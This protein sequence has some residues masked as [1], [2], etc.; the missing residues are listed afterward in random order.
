[1]SN[2][3]SVS[4]AGTSLRPAPYVSTTYEYN[5][6][7]QYVI[8]GFLVVTL[9]GTVVDKDII[10]AIKSLSALQ[11]NSDCVSLTIGCSGGTDFI[12]GSGR[13]RS[14]TINPSDQP[15][16]VSYSV[17]I[18]LETIDNNPA[19]EADDEFVNSNCLTA[20]VS[21]LQSYS[22]TL[23]VS[24]DANTI[25]SVDKA[26]DVSKSYI[27]ASGKIV[28]VSYMRN[29][30]GFPNYNGLDNSI[31]ILEDRAKSLMNMNV[32]SI[33]NDNPLSQ[34]SGWNKWLD[35]KSLTIDSNGVVTWSFDMY[36][37][38]GGATPFA[39][40]DIDTEDSQDQQRKSVNL[41]RR[42]SGSIKG[43]SSANISD[44]LANRVD[45][46]ERLSNAKSAFS[47][48]SGIITN[49][50]WPEDS[51]V[52]T[53]ELNCTPPPPSSC[54]PQEEELCLQ[55]ISST[56]KESPISGEITFNAEFAPISACQPR[57][58]GKVDL[59]VEENLP[60]ERHVEYII[61]GNIDSVVVSLNAKTPHRVNISVRGSL[62]GC[63]KTKMDELK[64]CVKKALDKEVDKLKGVWLPLNETEQVGTYSY[65]LGKEFILCD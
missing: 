41:T 1:M 62:Q 49:G 42:I 4:L 43:L 45:A 5:K 59:T 39:W 17:Q 25:S 52:L 18:A 12:N 10:N 11:K 40:V 36:M 7:G 54:P 33:T 44:Y 56:I 9:S 27:K 31:K 63:D 20:P 38:Q 32:C 34:F 24:G 64:T 46:N 8:G 14:V 53:G 60:A 51:I 37:S 55:R 58:I 22:E 65:S 13:I 30:C 19:V 6:S 3:D 15:F 2:F 57:G 16:I 35:T 48:L 21:F 50:S 23:S 28:L 29:I 26:L 61:P 47:I